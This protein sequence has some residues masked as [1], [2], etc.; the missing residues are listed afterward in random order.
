MFDQR[1]EFVGQ[2]RQRFVPENGRAELWIIGRRGR[3]RFFKRRF[4]EPAKL[5]RLVD[6][7]HV[8]QLLLVPITGLREYTASA[9]FIFEPPP[10][11]MGS[12]MQVARS[13]SA[14][15]ASSL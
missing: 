14:A 9:V 12:T 15:R 5:R 3:Q 6:R 4:D 2:P 1:R 13:I 10:R 7:K 8:R 11:V